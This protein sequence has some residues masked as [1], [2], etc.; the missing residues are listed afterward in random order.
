[1]NKFKIYIIKILILPIFILFSCVVNCKNISIDNINI[2]GIN[3]SLSSS[4]LEKIM[5]NNSISSR[6]LLK[7]INNFSVFDRIC[8]Y[9]KNK[10]LYLYLNEKAK[11]S[12]IFVNNSKIKS[13]IFSILYKNNL[14]VGEY[15][16]GSKIKLIKNEIL[17][18][19]KNLDFYNVDLNM[20]A[21]LNPDKNTINF[22]ININLLNKKYIKNIKFLGNTVFNDNKL[23][24]ILG[25]TK[26]NNISFFLKNECLNKT[27]LFIALENIKSYYLDKGYVDFQINYVRVFLTKNHKYCNIIIDLFEGE[28]YTIEYSDIIADFSKL[29]KSLQDK[30]YEILYSSISAGDIFCR[31]KIIEVKQKLKDL[32]IEYGNI[33]TQIEYSILFIDYLKLKIEFIIK[34]DNKLF[35]RNVNFSGNSTISDERLREMIPN[36]EYTYVLS[37]DILNGKEE[38]MRSGFVKFVGMDFNYIDS[39]NKNEVDL[40]YKII[41]NKSNKVSL[42][43]NISREDGLLLNFLIDAPN[44]LGFGKDF[45][46]NLNKNKSKSDLSFSYID[47]MV[48]YIGMSSGFNIYYKTDK[49]DRKISPFNSSKNIFGSYL[50]YTYY[51]N[52]VDK[53]NL[54]FGCDVTSI[55][56][57]FDFISNEVKHF[58][59]KEGSIYRDFYISFNFIR[60]SIDK[61]LFPSKGSSQIFKAKINLPGSKLTYYTLT[62]DS[63]FYKSFYKNKY[64]LNIYSNLYYGNGYS[65]FNKK[66]IFPFFKHFNIRGMNNIRGFKQKTLG[67]RDSNFDLIGGNLLLLSK[68]SIF[69]NNNNNFLNIKNVRYSIFLDVGQ[70]YNTKSFYNKTFLNITKSIFNDIKLSLGFST[71]WNTP[72]GIPFDF[73]V[74]YPLNV[75]EGRDRISYVSMSLGMILPSY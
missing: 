42:G 44:F 38:I 71:S 12:D 2:Y 55:R 57:N 16:D 10:S 20:K 41:E 69:F 26:F 48:S 74:A 39:K 56:S 47:P 70:V 53:I 15:F 22:Y 8:F 6:E 17:K 19:C 29:N 73:S 3:N 62:Y 64:I 63:S 61:I 67:P 65:F 58:I 23:F 24:K 14:I 75:V 21:I 7:S 37:S 45:N 49:I 28:K 9:K 43:F 4:L 30:A 46:I 5:F 40:N 66:T 52:N 59:E 1:M 34:I 13:F 54:G 31:N 60:R 50:Y 25:L 32:F 68:I 36:M 11:I 35:I 33:N 27:K 51:I 72:F 18:H